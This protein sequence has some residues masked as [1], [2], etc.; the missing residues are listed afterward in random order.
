M[1]AALAFSTLLFA[2]ASCSSHQP[3]PIGCN[4]PSDLSKLSGIYKSSEKLTINQFGPINSSSTW[5][6]KFD[7][8]GHIT[9]EKSWTSNKI[10]GHNDTGKKVRSDSEAI[11][12]L[13]KNC[14]IALVETQE[15][16]M[17]HAELMEDQSI[18]VSMLQSGD[19]PVVTMLT[20]V[21]SK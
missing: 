6:L 1:K 19:K 18:M 7:K 4:E 16:G 9:G 11:I 15:T 21:K 3:R 13:I 2:V 12:G 8:K 10:V 20:L 14:K 5:N 17:A